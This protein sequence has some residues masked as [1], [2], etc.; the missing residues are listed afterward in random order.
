[1][2]FN[3]PPETSLAGAEPLGPAE[4]GLHAWPERPF[5]SGCRQSVGCAQSRDAPPPGLSESS[6]P[7]PGHTVR[8]LG[9]CR[10]STAVT[11][12]RAQRTPVSSCTGPPWSSHPVAPL[13]KHPAWLPIASAAD[14][15]LFPGG[16]FPPPSLSFLVTP[17]HR[18]TVQ[19]QWIGVPCRTPEVC[20]PCSPLLGCHTCSADHLD[21]HG[22]LHCCPCH[23]VAQ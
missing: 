15:G 4:R 6:L 5:V 2:S 19:I 3:S 22:S 13:L 11:R 18:V 9:P 20:A 17:P 10:K 7:P 8:G 21:C 23:N 14:S 12:R 16:P 1:M